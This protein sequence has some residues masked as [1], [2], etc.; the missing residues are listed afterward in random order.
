MFTPAIDKLQFAFQENKSTSDAVLILLHLVLRHLDNNSRNYARVLFLDFASAFNTMVPDVLINKMLSLNIPK[1]LCLWTLNFLLDRLQYIKHS[2]GIT[3]CKRINTGSPQ[4]C[5]LSPI[6]FVMYTNELTATHSSNILLKFAD[7]TALI[8]RIEGD[9][10]SKFHD[11]ISKTIRWCHDNQLHLNVTKTKE[12][13]FD[14]RKDKET[15]DDVII[16]GKKIEKVCHY[17]YLGVYLDDKLS[18]AL[19]AAEQ[20]KKM[21]RRMYCVKRLR[22][23]GVSRFLI[24]LAYN[25]FVGSVTNYCSQVFLPLLSNKDRRIFLSIP[26]EAE[27]MGLA[28]VPSVQKKIKERAIKTVQDII[29]DPE[30]YLHEDISSC[31]ASGRTRARTRM[32]FCRTERFLKSMIP[33]ALKTLSNSL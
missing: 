18:L 16:N 1:Y 26:R 3:T 11:D 27:R 14:F 21:T 20:K 13:V 12:V 4:G 28:H 8:G 9:D 17:K 6:L 24:Q 33:D 32:I 15:V 10:A 19:H 5:V 31:L 2:E 30:H 29:C 22:K 25:S 23:I 7:D